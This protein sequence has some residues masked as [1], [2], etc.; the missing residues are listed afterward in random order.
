MVEN[1][2]NVGSPVS[3]INVA[4]ICPIFTKMNYFNLL[5]PQFT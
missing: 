5:M 4:E 2:N 3:N 1:L